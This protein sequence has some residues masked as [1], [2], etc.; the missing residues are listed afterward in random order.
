MIENFLN[1]S[2]KMKI[3]VILVPIIIISSVAGVIILNKQNTKTE[4]TLSLIHI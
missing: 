3:I 2:I 1:L 4:L